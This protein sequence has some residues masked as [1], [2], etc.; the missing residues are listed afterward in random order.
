MSYKWK[1]NASQRAAFKERM[2]TPV[3]QAEYYTAKQEKAGK[4]RSKSNFDYE[5]A[6]GSYIPTE[7]QARFCI[8]HDDLFKT[9]REDTARLEVMMCFDDHCKTHHDNIHIVNEK[10]REY[11]LTQKEV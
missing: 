6:G 7:Y 1:P 11:N 2:S 10:I 9:I 5:T 4:R 8:Q 3:G